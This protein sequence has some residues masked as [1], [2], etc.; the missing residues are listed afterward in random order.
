[1]DTPAVL[2]TVRDTLTARRVFGDPIAVG[3]TTI[4]PVA[5]VRGGGGGAVGGGGFG[6]DAKPVGVFAVRG[7]RVQWKPAVNVNQIIAG[8]QMVGALAVLTL[9]PAI[10]AWALKRRT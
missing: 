5:K 7:D 6:V 8:G 4:I 2:T 3:D 1:M 9:G 10:L